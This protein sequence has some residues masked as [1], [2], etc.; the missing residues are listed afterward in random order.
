M[1]IFEKTQT[2]AAPST[3]KPVSPNCGALTAAIP[4]V[5]EP[6]FSHFSNHLMKQ[7]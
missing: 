3:F 7:N 2:I 5:K 4:A 6:I 1:K